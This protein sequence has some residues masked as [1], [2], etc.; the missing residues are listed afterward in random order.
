MNTAAAA[1]A[2]LGI[3]E[4]QAWKAISSS[5]EL[6]LFPDEK[7]SPAHYGLSHIF[8]RK[9]RLAYIQA[10]FD[11]LCDEARGIPPR[12]EQW[13]TRPTELENFAVL[14]NFQAAV[15]GPLPSAYLRFFE[16][17]DNEVEKMWFLRKFK[18][19]IES[20][21]QA[22]HWQEL[23]D[24]EA[25]VQD[26]IMPIEGSRSAQLEAIPATDSYRRRKFM[27]EHSK[28]LETEFNQKRRR[29]ELSLKP[30]TADAEPATL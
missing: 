26:A 11:K 10:N 30:P 7:L 22:R 19:E 20:G 1:D 18:P 23:R 27:E 21:L 5:W 6:R 4:Y 24:K 3:R 25:R 13:S 17:L 2:E 15:F 8:D 28:E 16:S 14:Q 9:V 12:V 29:V